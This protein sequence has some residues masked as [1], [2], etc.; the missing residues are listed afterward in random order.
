MVAVTE[1]SLTSLG[2][3]LGAIRRERELELI[4]ELTLVGSH[5]AAAVLGDDSSQRLRP[6]GIPPSDEV[7]AIVFEYWRFV[8]ETAARRVDP[9]RLRCARAR[10]GALR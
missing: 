3:H 4:A 5:Y 2:A 10:R 8:T 6:R 1:R 7:F 9:G